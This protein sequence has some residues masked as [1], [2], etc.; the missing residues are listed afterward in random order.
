VYLRD[1]GQIIGIFVPA[2]MFLSPIFY[3]ISS[4]PE[5]LQSIILINPLTI[6]VEEA[7]NF[8]FWGAEID[9]NYLS[10]YWVVSLLICCIGFACFQ[11]MR[12]GFAD[13]I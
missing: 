2:L 10:I 6:P 1:I 5:G 8:L 3:R 12:K 4:L 9:Y 13:V 11:K 7:R